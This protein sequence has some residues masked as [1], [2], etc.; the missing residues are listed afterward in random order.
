MANQEKDSHLKYSHKGNNKPFS[1]HDKRHVP[2]EDPELTHTDP[3]TPMGEF[4]R[5]FWHPICMSEELTDVPKALKIFGEDLVAF[6]DK[7]GQIGLMH[8][9]CCHRGASL[10]YGIIQDQG[11][12][13]CY[14]GFHYDVDGTLI[15]VPGEADRGKRL[16]QHVSQGAYPAREQDGLVFAY[17]GPYEEMPE[18]PEWDWGTAYDDL[19]L[20]PFSNIYPCNYL[21]VFDN[22]ADQVHTAHLHHSRMRVVSEDGEDEYPETALNP[23]FTQLPVMDYSPIRDDSAMV[24]MAG[25]R[26]GTDKVWVRMNE[27]I[28]PNA[29][30][31]ANLFEDGRDTR[32]WHRVHM[33]R[34]YV[35]VD[36]ENSLILGW[37]MF[38][39][40]I[41]PFDKGIRERCTYDDIDF[42][43]GQ[44]GNRPY[45]AGQRMPGDWEALTSQRSIAVHD[46][47][48]PMRGDIGVYMNRKIMRRALNG[49]NPAAQPEKLHERAN[50]GLP[51]KTYTHNTVLAIP[52]RDGEDDEILI[53]E[54]MHHLLGIIQEGDAYE[55]E[56][57]ET[58][59]RNKMQDY[60]R[61]FAG[62]AAAE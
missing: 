44:V 48:N 25:R 12:V 11:I 32:Y 8:R 50:T 20:V 21:Q 40:K 10:E 46:L 45:E 42:L 41:D 39:K 62:A 19:E 7:S 51:E 3:D 24:F 38:G 55:G 49:D 53:L 35:P 23:V 31:H 36:D 37:R 33:A 9:H 54:V 17:M 61:S 14:H 57:R 29:T 5:Q 4:M 58:F 1:G 30:W 28:L 47:E 15:D 26:V 16:S 27:L 6:R 22:I 52:M 59:I 43:V 60:E 56:E 13:C 18:F 34:W 2:S